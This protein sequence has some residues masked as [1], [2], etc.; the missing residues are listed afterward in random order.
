MRNLTAAAFLAVIA[1]TASA[2]I[3]VSEVVDGDLAGGNP[4]FVEITNTGGTDFTF[5]TGGIIIQSN[6]ATDVTVD[7]D[8]S[9]VT[10]LAG[11]SFVVASSA[12]GGIAQFQAAYGFD[13]DL[14]TG[15]FFG[16]GDDRYAIDIAG[17]VVDIFGVFGSNAAPDLATYNYTDSYAYRVASS[18]T[19]GGTTYVAA[20]WVLGGVAALDAGDDATRIALLQANT[21]P[22]T[23]DFVPA[24]AS[25]ALMGL[26][27]LMAARRRR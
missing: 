17:T 2:D 9:G 15:V 25:A 4:K 8:L 24:P 22:G 16:N 11:Q 10:I 26:G 20:D 12:N 3:I 6:A 19:G 5:G 13:A 14:Y 27:G 18:I 23:H 1:G 21:T 7:V